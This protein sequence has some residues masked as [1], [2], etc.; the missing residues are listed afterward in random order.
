MYVKGTKKNNDLYILRPLRS[1]RLFLFRQSTAVNEEERSSVEV[2][3]CGIGEHYRLGH[4][5]SIKLISILVYLAS[6][7]NTYF[8]DRVIH[9]LPPFVML[10]DIRV[11]VGAAIK[12][13][14][15]KDGTEIIL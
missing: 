7:E 13:V 12:A 3:T 10:S 1:N 8:C 15:N 14:M 5:S 11:D 4:L 6:K 2:K 9:N